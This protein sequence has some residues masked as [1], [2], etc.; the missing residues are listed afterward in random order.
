MMTKSIQESLTTPVVDQA[1]VLVLGGGPAG[2]AAAIAAA[3]AGSDVIL[4]E[5]Y[6]HLGG[7]GT[8]GYVLYMDCLFDRQGRRWTDG[9]MQETLQRLEDLNGLDYDHPLWLNVDSEL[10]K[11]VAEEM[12]LEAGVRLRYH[13]WAVST[14]TEGKTVKGVVLESKAGRQ[15]ILAKV[16]ID[17]TGD[18][19]I[20]ASAGAQFSLNHMRIAL[21]MKVA[22]VDWQAYQRYIKE[23]NATYRQQMLELRRMQAYN[24]SL[25]GTPHRQHG[26]FWV[27][28]PG[29]GRRGQIDEGEWRENDLD[30]DQ[31]HGE[32]SALD[33]QDLTYVEIEVRQRIMRS[34]EYY[35][36]HIP[37]FAQV[38]IVG[39]ASQVGVRDSRHIH[40]LHI[41]TKEDV[42]S[43]HRF[44]DSI[45]VA[46][47]N[48]A[49]DVQVYPIPY[50]CLVP[51]DLDGLL[52]AGRC[53]SVDHWVTNST[54]LIPACVM[55]G[56]AA[57]S[58][59]ALAV[60]AN[61]QPKEQNIRQLREHLKA[62]DVILEAE[63]A[64][65]V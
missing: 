44:E 33:P 47:I 7:L 24:L 59:A 16:C 46:V 27:N 42:L 57:G 37:G 65:T 6:G 34:I 35:R 48:Y 45:G 5:R 64:Q 32:L 41:L 8:G 56:Q 25:H 23:E 62:S 60:R 13:T 38:A 55:M 12:S 63:T 53:I 31:F 11:I 1:D 39:F 61:V 3:R 58:A 28:N 36:Q 22:G 29:L 54:R 2:Y 43:Q 50:R 26:V 9:V 10:F 14:I 49:K 40:G 19:D 21:N 20:A 18:G 17:A 15:A 30:S 4:I 51:K 52:V